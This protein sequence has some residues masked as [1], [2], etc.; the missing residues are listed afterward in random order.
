MGES[1]I[2][3]R[4]VTRRREGRKRREEKRT[5]ETERD[6]GDKSREEK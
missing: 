5:V 3:G 4:V 6:L 2:G 1:T